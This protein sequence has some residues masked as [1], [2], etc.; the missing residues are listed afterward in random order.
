[1]ELVKIAG[2]SIGVAAVAGAEDN[3]LS[4]FFVSHICEPCTISSF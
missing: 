2:I 1:M 3:V 4:G